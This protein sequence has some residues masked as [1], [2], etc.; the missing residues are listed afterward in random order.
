MRRFL[1]LLIF[2][3]PLP[4]K[5]L[6]VRVHPGEFVYAYEVDPARGLYDVMLQNIAVVQK[7]GPPVTVE[8]I[9]IQAVAN[10]QTVQTLV[11]PAAYLDKSAQ[12]LIPERQG[13]ARLPPQ[14]RLPRKARLRHPAIRP[15]RRYL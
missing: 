10:G 9:E 11:V 12:R 6:E 8:S 3:L 4:A 7:D 1:T 14:A 2:L 5:A 13:V 15:R